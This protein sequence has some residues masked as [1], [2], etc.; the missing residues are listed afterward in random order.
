MENGWSKTVARMY[1]VIKI[2][3]SVAGHGKADIIILVCKKSEPT[4][5]TSL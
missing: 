5:K 4:T 3:G 1:D 2:F